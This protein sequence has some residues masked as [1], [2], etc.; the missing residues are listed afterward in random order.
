MSKTTCSSI[1]IKSVHRVNNKLITILNNYLLENKPQLE[2][3]ETS[4]KIFL[5]D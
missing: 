5:I 1:D 4:K 2:A 3:K